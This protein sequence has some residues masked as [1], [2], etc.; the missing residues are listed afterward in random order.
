MALGHSAKIVKNGLV[1]YLD[2][3]NT[4]SYV[5]SGTTWY[6]LS[7]NGNNGSL[8]N[9]VGY[10]AD[11]NGSLMFDGVDDVVNTNNNTQ[12]TDFTVNVWFKSTGGTLN[13]NRI[14]DKN[15]INGFWIG[16]QNNIVNSWGGGVLE[17][18]APYGRYITLTDNQWHMIAFLRQGTTHK[19]YGDGIDN[20]VSGTVSGNPLGSTS[21]AIGNWSGANNVQRLTGNV[22]CVQIYNR[23]LSTTEIKQNFNAH[24]GRYGI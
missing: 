16:R 5:G 9:G 14:I 7:G 23:A 17:S 2:A 15:Y 8:I 21:I 3:A 6:D 18:T 10:I 12:F 24:R 1:L 11:N 4:K 13:Y 20:Y 19:I 22:S